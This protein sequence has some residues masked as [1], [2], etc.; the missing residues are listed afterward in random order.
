MNNNLAL[1][2]VEAILENLEGR[3][4]FDHWRYDIDRATWAELKQSLCD[5]AVRVLASWGLNEKGEPRV[6]G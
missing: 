1:A 5:D 6:D 4:G 2:I 3:A